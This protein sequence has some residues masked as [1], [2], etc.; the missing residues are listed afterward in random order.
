MRKNMENHDEQLYLVGGLRN[1]NG[2]WLSR[3][4]WEWKII[5][6]DEW[7]PS[8]FRGV[9]IPPT[10]GYWC[11]NPGYSW[12]YHGDIWFSIVK[13]L[14]RCFPRKLLI[15]VQEPRI[16]T[17]KLLPCFFLCWNLE[18][19][20]CLKHHSWYPLSTCQAVEL[21]T[22]VCNS[23]LSACANA[24]RWQVTLGKSHGSLR[25]TFYK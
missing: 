19:F 13:F 18:P 14:W 22:V 3:N 10:R 25:K 20:C 15:L 9:G 1:M 16:S 5:P 12:K 21:D 4:S 2:L 24:A 6:T 11:F 7:T 17:A 23:C 8:F